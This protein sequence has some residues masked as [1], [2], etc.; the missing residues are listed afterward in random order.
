MK[1]KIIITTL[2]LLLITIPV[3]AI[4]DI[5]LEAKPASEVKEIGFACSSFTSPTLRVYLTRKTTPPGKVYFY[6]DIYYDDLLGTAYYI[7]RTDILN[8]YVFIP[9]TPGEPIRSQFYG[10]GFIFNAWE[11]TSFYYV[12]KGKTCAQLKSYHFVYGFSTKPD[13]S[14]FEGAAF[15]IE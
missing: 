1:L 7:A 15:R 3:F 4:T 10:T 12:F 13:L 11:D 8:R 5:W 6:S 9:Y 14:D 2:F